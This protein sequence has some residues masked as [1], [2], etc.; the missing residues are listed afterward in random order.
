MSG[1]MTMNKNSIRWSGGVVINA[2]GMYSSPRW[3]G[4]GV[5]GDGSIGDNWLGWV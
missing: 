1:G 5:D 2:G 4:P 3:M